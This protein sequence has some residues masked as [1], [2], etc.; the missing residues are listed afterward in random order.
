M[1]NQVAPLV[2]YSCLFMAYGCS[3]YQSWLAKTISADMKNRG[4]DWNSSSTFGPCQP[5]CPVNLFIS[6]RMLDYFDIVIRAI[7][8]TQNNA[9]KVTRNK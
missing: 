3:Q 5:D 1:F 6:Y 7:V 4:Q 2:L 9:Y 8:R